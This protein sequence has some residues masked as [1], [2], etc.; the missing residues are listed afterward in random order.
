MAFQRRDNTVPV[1][2]LNK[3]VRN[4]QAFCEALI[5]SAACDH[6]IK[7]LETLATEPTNESNTAMILDQELY[8]VTLFMNP[9][10]ENV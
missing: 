8:L 6:T 10:E 1:G 5:Y 3:A 4:M 7:A 9:L 2:P